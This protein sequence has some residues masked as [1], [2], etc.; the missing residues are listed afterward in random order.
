MMDPDVSEAVQ[1]RVAETLQRVLLPTLAGTV[2]GAL[3]FPPISLVLQHTFDQGILS[4]LSYDSSQ[5]IQNFVNGEWSRA[6]R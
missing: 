5:I 1:R 2:A 3:T 4:I 6:E